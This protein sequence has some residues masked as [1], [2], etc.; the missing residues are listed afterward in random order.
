MT[1]ET[2]RYPFTTI[3]FSVA[4]PVMRKKSKSNRTLQ[5]S[6]SRQN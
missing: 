3:E 5:K 2:R 1:R 6:R 4:A